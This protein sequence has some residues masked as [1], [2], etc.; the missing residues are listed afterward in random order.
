ME[1]DG[2]MEVDGVSCPEEEG[3]SAS[4]PKEEDASVATTTTLRT[5]SLEPKSKI[6][7]RRKKK[8]SKTKR[9]IHH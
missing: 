3:I 7:N 9:K 2:E 8:S 5:P 1:V 6:S 4:D